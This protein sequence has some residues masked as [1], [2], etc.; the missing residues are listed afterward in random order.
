[1]WGSSCTDIIALSSANSTTDVD[2][3]VG[4]SAA[5]ILYSIGERM[6]PWGTP[7]LI[8]SIFEKE[9]IVY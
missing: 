2:G 7:A 6:P 9:A 5:Y 1:M 3:E 4:W 8:F